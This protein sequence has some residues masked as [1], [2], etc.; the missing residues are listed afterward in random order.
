MF[1]WYEAWFNML[2]QGNDQ[3]T[4]QNSIAQRSIT[5]TTATTINTINNN[6]AEQP[7]D[8]QKLSA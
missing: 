5:R 8:N 7:H 1:S 4:A 6:T 3:L 2:G